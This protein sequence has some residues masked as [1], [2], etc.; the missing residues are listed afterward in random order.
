MLQFIDIY[1][2]DNVINFAHVNDPWDLQAGEILQCI[3]FPAVH[4]NMK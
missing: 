2:S 3:T 1:V 4:K